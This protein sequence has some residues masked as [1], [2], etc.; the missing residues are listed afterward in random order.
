M[1]SGYIRSAVGM[2]NDDLNVTNFDKA[3]NRSSVGFSKSGVSGK[4]IINVDGSSLLSNQKRLAIP[5]A[6]PANKA[7]I[8][9]RLVIL[10]SD[11]SRYPYRVDKKISCWIDTGI[12]PDLT[13]HTFF[14][15]FV[16]VGKNE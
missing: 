7:T 4:L 2:S 12:S 15:C 13:K 9:A 5:P 10:K 1:N 14:L 8:R 16:D 11:K 3:T 6:A